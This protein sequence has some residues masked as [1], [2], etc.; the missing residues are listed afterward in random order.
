[1]NKP[2]LQPVPLADGLRWR[3]G[4]PFLFQEKA[5][6]VH[7]FVTCAAGVSD[8]PV[9]N[10]LKNGW[11][12]EV[13]LQTRHYSLFNAEQ[14]PDGSIILNDLIFLDGQDLRRE[15]TRVRW[16]ELQRCEVRGARCQ[17]CASGNGGELLEAILARGGEG[18]VAKAW[19]APFGVNWYKCKRSETF[20]LR[21]SEIDYARGS[22]RLASEAGED[23]G[24]C[25]ARAAFEALRPGQIVEVAALCLTAK[26][27]LREPR[28]VRVRKD[29]NK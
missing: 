4:G 24:W 3:G 23:R 1:M 29:K 28:F 21:I 10:V 19:E 6:G 18:V 13:E 25:P 27:K 7:C 14:M 22:L 5:D 9:F 12:Q 26:G 20:D 16:A 17:V 2:T 8:P 15:P 11:S